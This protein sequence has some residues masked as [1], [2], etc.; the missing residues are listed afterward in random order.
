MDQNG[1]SITSIY[2]SN[3]FSNSVLK[4]RL[5][6]NY[7]DQLKHVQRG[8]QRLTEELSER[9]ALAMKEWAVEKGATHYTHWFQ[10]LT[11]STAEKHDS[12]IEPTT[13]GNVLLNFSG[14]SL[15]QGEPDAS[16]FPSGGLRETFEARGYTAWDT[17][18][19]AFLRTD[20]SGTTLTIPTA[21][22]SYHGH[23]LDTKTPLLKSMRA[24]SDQSMRVLR[25]L[26]NKRSKKVIT[27]VGPEQEYFLIDRKFLEKRPDL[28]LTGRT[29]FGSMP[30][31]GQELYD[32]YFGTIK[33]RVKVFMRELN[34]ELWKLGISAKTQHNEVAPNQ[35]ELANVFSTANIA[36]DNNQIGMELMERIAEKHGL[37]CLLHEKPFQGVNGSGKH[38]NWSLSTDDGINLFE[39]GDDPHENKQFLLLLVTVLKAVDKYA[40]LLRYSA[41][42]RGNDLRLGGHEAP[43]SVISV[44][45]GDT[46]TSILD[47][48]AEGKEAVVNGQ[49]MVKMGT[50]NLPR[51]LKDATDRNRTSPFAF[52]GNRFEFRMA[53]SSGSIAEPNIILNSAVAEVLSE[54]SYRLET[55]E[56][57]E[58][59]TEQIIRDFYKEHKEIVFNGDGYSQ[60]WFDEA[61]RRGLKNYPTTI[62]VLPEIK[63]ETAAELFKRQNVFTLPE[64]ES[65]F[66]VG[67]EKYIKELNIEASVMVEMAKLQIVPAALRYAGKIASSISDSKNLLKDLN[68]EAEEDMLREIH[69]NVSALLKKT[70]KLSAAG[71]NLMEEDFEYE[72][73]YE[74]KDKLLPLMDEVRE[75]G[76][77]LE[78][79][80]GKDDWPFP[81]YEEMLFQM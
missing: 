16:S 30:S 81:G 38:N 62:D 7:Y 61:E 11:G 80:T 33:E 47:R 28:L 35:F 9:V 59:E 29:V 71:L 24:I 44:F 34:V 77:N 60:E 79:L 75:H 36:A 52:T 56:D 32:H 53:P 15:L 3:L 55:A 73:A 51:L 13:D 8:E 25:A 6:Q 18:S 50:S 54:V 46:L 48:I 27:T 31:K 43:P 23:A 19:P 2:G 64:L 37:I 5:P 49:D 70:N 72:K 45:L 63:S 57:K 20:A 41:A 76:D 68:T 17:T 26:G 58:K 40:P 67:V 21:F 22:I 4:E 66:N 78:C 69:S 12:F 65:R 74:L 1:F 42:N 14:K 10:P 39:P